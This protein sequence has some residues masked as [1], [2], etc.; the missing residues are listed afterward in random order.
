M[1]KEQKTQLARV[2][3]FID[4]L[5]QHEN[6]EG[7]ILLDSEMDSFGAADPLGYQNGGNC[8]NTLPG[9]CGSN[10]GDCSNTGTPCMNSTNKG[11]CDNKIII[12][13]V[14]VGLNCQQVCAS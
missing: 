7:V 3:D 4:S 8:T 9:S 2:N 11:D 13:P 10:G 12:P 14:I 1:S 6:P 5:G